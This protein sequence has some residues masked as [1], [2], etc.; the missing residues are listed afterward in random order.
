[1]VDIATVRS[2][3]DGILTSKFQTAYI[4]TFAAITKKVPISESL[5]GDELS[6]TLA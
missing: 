3:I 1:M 4:F 6:E 2:N 5:D